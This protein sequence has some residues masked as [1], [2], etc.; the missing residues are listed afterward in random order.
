MKTAVLIQ[1]HSNL[2]YILLLIKKNKNIYFI[3][4]FDKKFMIPEKSLSD[5]KKNNN[6]LV[7]EGINRVEVFWGGYSQLRATLN[8]INVANKIEGIELFHFISA[9]CLQLLDFEKIYDEWLSLGSKNFIECRK[10][11]SS[12]W[13]LKVKVFYSETKFT[14]SFLGRVSNR[15]HK[16]IGNKFNPCKWDD[17]LQWYG[18]CWFSLN[19]FMINE[20]SNYD[21]NYNYFEK[22]KYHPCVDEHALQ[23]FAK[24]KNIEVTDNN[25][26]LVLFKGEKSSPEYFNNLTIEDLISYRNLGY[27]FLRKVNQKESMSFLKIDKDKY[28]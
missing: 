25:K 7:L 3:I 9:E 23:V 21:M 18:S 5:I 20:I 26:R 15:L 28:D 17:H 12:E 19:R 14:R 6:V 11:L 8:L 4:H 16:I 22:F 2:D 10:R 1:A 24:E 27:W 13:R